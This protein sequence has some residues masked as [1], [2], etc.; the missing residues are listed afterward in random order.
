MRR[1]SAR[2]TARP[3]APDRTPRR[4]CG[5]RGSLRSV[6]TRARAMQPPAQRLAAGERHDGIG[7]ERQGLRQDPVL[8]YQ[9][10]PLLVARQAVEVGAMEAGERLE[11]IEAPLRLEDARIE[12]E[13]MG[14]GIAARACGRMLLQA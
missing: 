10:H 1:G 5:S 7:P 14:R 8:A 4:R 11:A 13:R 6:G 9:L 2:P 12:L 3:R